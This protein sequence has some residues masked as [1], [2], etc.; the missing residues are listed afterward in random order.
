MNLIMSYTSLK[1]IEGNNWARSHDDV[2]KWKHFPRYWA[3]VWDVSFDLRLNKWLSKQSRRQWFETPPR[4]FWRHCNAL[5][6]NIQRIIRIVH[7]V[8][9]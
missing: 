8:Y 7:S 9:M 4:S 5:I 1:Y 2:I 3:F 6:H